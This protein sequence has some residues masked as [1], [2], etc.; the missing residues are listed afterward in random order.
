MS[1]TLNRI[2]LA[3]VVMGLAFKGVSRQASAELVVNGDFEDGKL[4]GLV[5]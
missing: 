2:G 5:V 3:L 4:H 1:A